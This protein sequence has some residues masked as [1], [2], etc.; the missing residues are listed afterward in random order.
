MHKM[1]T[2]ISKKSTNITRL[3]RFFFF[4]QNSD[5]Q[6]Q[7]EDTLTDTICRNAHRVQ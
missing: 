6:I 4:I 5:L 7:N 3:L 2:R 1:I